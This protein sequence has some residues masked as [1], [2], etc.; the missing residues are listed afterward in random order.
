MESELFLSILRYRREP[1]LRSHNIQEPVTFLF[2]K[3]EIKLRGVFFSEKCMK[4][5]CESKFWKI[6][7]FPVI[8]FE[9]WPFYHHVPSI[10]KNETSFVIR[11]YP[12]IYFDFQNFIASFLDKSIFQLLRSGC[13]RIPNIERN[14]SNSISF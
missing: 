1:G 12:E 5:C 8:T 11:F 13:L 9:I 2:S 10:S 14:N 4:F 7:L 6:W 3:R